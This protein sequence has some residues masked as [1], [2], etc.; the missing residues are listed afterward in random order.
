M[1]VRGNKAWKGHCR[2]WWMAALHIYNVIFLLSS[3]HKWCNDAFIVV[4]LCRPHVL[5]VSW[6]QERHVS[7]FFERCGESKKNV[8][9]VLSSLRPPLKVGE[10]KKEG[11]KNW[12]E[13]E[14]PQDVWS[15]CRRPGLPAHIGCNQ[16]GGVCYESAGLPWDEGHSNLWP[17]QRRNVTKT[18]KE[19]GKWTSLKEWSSFEEKIPRALKK[20]VY[21]KRRRQMVKSSVLFVVT[22]VCLCARVF[23]YVHFVTLRF[24]AGHGSVWPTRVLN[25]TNG[26]FR[27]NDGEKKWWILRC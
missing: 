21:F 9:L 25:R 23:V 14:I 27:W 11:K 22:C 3:A 26:R 13:E 2:L 10:G 17:L 15:T 6:I 7:V 20:K 8:R 4:S 18:A 5:L 16:N 19:T 1:D 24:I 12:T